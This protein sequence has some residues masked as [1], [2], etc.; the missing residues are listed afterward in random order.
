[1]A[2]ELLWRDNLP[3]HNLLPAL[4]GRAPLPVGRGL[5]AGRPL[6]ANSAYAFTAMPTGHETPVPPSPQ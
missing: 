2:L 6:A 1:M 3:R 5:P 4:L